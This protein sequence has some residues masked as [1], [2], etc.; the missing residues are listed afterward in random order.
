MNNNNFIL[1]MGES[2]SGKTAVANAL[3]EKYG[4]SQVV[5]YTTREKRSHNEDCHIF[6]SDNEFDELEDLVAYTEYNGHRYGATAQQVEENYIYVIDPDGVD[7]FMEAYNGTKTPI[8]IYLSVPEETRCCRL[9]G[10]DGMYNAMERI[11]YDRKAFANAKI[12]ADVVVE[13]DNLTK[14]VDEIYG[15]WKNG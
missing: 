10:R 15:I 3:Y 5:S 6:I 13:N 4:L 11:N 8:V 1:L 2:G 7:Y 9:I 12:M 14:C